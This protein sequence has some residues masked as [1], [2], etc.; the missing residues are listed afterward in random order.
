MKAK[1]IALILGLMML[2]TFL[3]VSAQTEEKPE[4]EAASCVVVQEKIQ[5]K[6]QT[7]QA[8]KPEHALTYQILYL[9][10]AAFAKK[11]EV[12]GYEVDEIYKNLDELEDFIE[13]FEENYEDFIDALEKADKSACGKEEIYAKD[14]VGAKEAL[15]DVRKS[16]MD[17]TQLYQE[18]IRQN[19]LSLED[20]ENE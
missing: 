10:L 4:T 17:I 3:V 20:V 12:L 1:F 2:P 5:E 7:Y 18:D 6:I 16:A 8:N 14:F 15:G 11:A 9:K 13:V 19:I